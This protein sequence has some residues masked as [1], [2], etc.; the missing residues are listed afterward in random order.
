MRYRLSPPLRKETKRICSP[1]GDQTGEKSAAASCVRF[2]GSL[3]SGFIVQISQFPSRLDENTTFAVVGA[4]ADVLTPLLNSRKLMQQN[5]AKN[6]TLIVFL[7]LGLEFFIFIKTGYFS[8]G[9]IGNAGGPD[10]SALLLL[11]TC[12]SWVFVVLSILILKSCLISPTS[13]R[14]IPC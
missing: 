14:W 8:L 2:T 7:L 12:V 4:F 13:G 9:W 5:K 6:L 1:V 10:Q 11:P 3:P